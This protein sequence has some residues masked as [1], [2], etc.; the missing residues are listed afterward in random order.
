MRIEHIN[1]I[2]YYQKNPHRF[3]ELTEDEL[4]TLTDVIG[5]YG[6]FCIVNNVDVRLSKQKIK[7]TT[8]KLIGGKV[9]S[10]SG[11]KKH[12]YEISRGLYSAFGIDSSNV[13]LSESN[14]IVLDHKISVNTGWKSMIPPNVI[15]DI[16]NLQKLSLADNFKKADYDFV[17]KYNQWIFDN[18]INI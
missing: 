15:S 14:S 9:Y 18:Y 7:Q 6:V 8:K 16:S 13:L 10:K 11:Y 17:D 3:V 4:L 12:C 5:D 2:I 1:T